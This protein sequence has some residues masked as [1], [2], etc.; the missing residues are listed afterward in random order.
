MK[1]AAVWVTVLLLLAACGDGD[2]GDNSSTGPQPHPQSVTVDEWNEYSEWCLEFAPEYKR[3]SCL[4]EADKFE[5]YVTW[6]HATRY[7][8]KICVERL[9]KQTIIGRS[10]DGRNEEISTLSEYCLV[11]SLACKEATATRYAGGAT[12][13]ERDLQAEACRPS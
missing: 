1:L 4:G 13:V 7:F 2:A 6:G 10:L 12:L 11:A 5:F 3:S 9:L 8:E